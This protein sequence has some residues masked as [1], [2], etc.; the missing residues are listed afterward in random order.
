MNNCAQLLSLFTFSNRLSLRCTA[1]LFPASST[2]RIIVYS[3]SVLL[4]VSF[5]KM[6]SAFV[7]RLLS[8]PIDMKPRSMACSSSTSPSSL[9]EHLFSS[10]ERLSVLTEASNSSVDSGT[11]DVYDDPEDHFYDEPL[12]PPEKPEPC[13]LDKKK[14]SKRSRFTSIIKSSSTSSVDTR[15]SYDDNRSISNQQDS[16]G[17]NSETERLLPNH[18]SSDFLHI[19]P[20]IRIITHHCKS[21]SSS[22]SSLSVSNLPPKPPRQSLTN[23]VATSLSPFNRTSQSSTPALPP[24]SSVKQNNQLK[25]NKPP[26]RPPP[27]VP[28]ESDID[29]AHSHNSSENMVDSSDCKENRAPRLMKKT[30]SLRELI[31]GP[32]NYLVTKEHTKHSSS[33]ANTPST[34]S[35]PSSFVNFFS[36]KS[37]NGSSMYE[38]AFDTG[39]FMVKSKSSHPQPPLP[40]I[41]ME[42]SINRNQLHRHSQNLK[43]LLNQNNGGN[44][45]ALISHQSSNGNGSVES[46]I[47]ITPDTSSR[48]STASSTCSSTDHEIASIINSQNSATISQNNHRNMRHQ[49]FIESHN[50]NQ[51]KSIF[52][53]R[54][55]IKT[56]LHI[57]RSKSSDV[58]T[59]TT[60]KVDS[61]D[62]EKLFCEAKRNRIKMGSASTCSMLKSATSDSLASISNQTNHDQRLEMP[63]TKQNGHSQLNR[64]MPRTRSSIMDSNIVCNQ[65]NS[66]ELNSASKNNGSC[67]PTSDRFR[68]DFT[69][70]GVSTFTCGPRLTSSMSH[71][72]FLSSLAQ[73]GNQTNSQNGNV[74]EAHQ[75]GQ[76]RIRRSFRPLDLKLNEVKSNSLNNGSLPSPSIQSPLTDTRPLDDYDTPWDASKRLTDVLKQLINTPSNEKVPDFPVNANNVVKSC[77]TEGN[78]IAVSR[79]GQT[80]NKERAPSEEFNVGTSTNTVDGDDNNNQ[81]IIPGP[82][83]SS[84]SSFDGQPQLHNQ[85]QATELKRDKSRKLSLPLGKC[86]SAL[87]EL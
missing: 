68:S 80:E 49:Q 18:R 42:G 59:S 37:R 64:L 40:G 28:R 35:P 45:A 3:I 33:Q 70:S 44:C 25:P 83:V 15:S 46:G 72:S 62:I 81:K 87:C 57:P 58:N 66:S 10:I 76:V 43:N 6:Q 61:I 48:S 47:S 22:E 30:L 31:I 86:I 55:G 82:S 54:L 38:T 36:T 52:P 69:S 21:S 29:C 71:S 8:L 19:E 26:Q 78:P 27:P 5:I 50:K 51:N 79:S 74:N 23:S 24:R 41:P 17:V 16:L 13:S 7:Q 32:D 56:N 12:L 73:S 1:L 39:V 65:L 84:S 67:T 9:N 14:K 20:E 34:T 60:H 63:S 77:L 2:P 53:R 75:Q 85:P 4:T 11:F